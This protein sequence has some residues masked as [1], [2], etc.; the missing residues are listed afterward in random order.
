MTSN[1]KRAEPL[2]EVRLKI[3]PEG[4]LLIPAAYR[5]ALGL[6]AGETVLLREQEGRLEILTASQKRNRARN[7]IAK[8]VSDDVSL[9]DS[10]IEDRRAE[11]ERESG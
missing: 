3:G 5:K 11:A 9:A 8:Y 4:R 2:P 6:R 1:T 7:V 10:L